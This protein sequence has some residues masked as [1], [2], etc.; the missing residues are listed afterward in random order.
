[1]ALNIIYAY[2]IFSTLLKTL[3]LN[4]STL[5]IVKLTYI[6]FIARLLTSQSNSDKLIIIVSMLFFLS[7]SLYIYI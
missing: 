4:T 1:M 6:F 2:L 3:P 7:I 5:K